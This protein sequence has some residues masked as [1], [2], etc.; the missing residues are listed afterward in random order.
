[1]WLAGSL[2]LMLGLLYL[3]SRAFKAIVRF[4]G[5]VWGLRGEQDLA[6][7]PLALLIFSVLSFLT[8]PAENYMQRVH[9]RASDRYAVEIT[10]DAQAGITA[11]QKLSRLSLSDPNPSPV[12]KFF[13]YS[14][15]TLTERIRDLAEMAKE[16]KKK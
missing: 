7:L 2:V 13:L 6:A 9:E 4:M 12:V 15:P 1:M 10:G 3:L 11:F 8:G 5:G 14:H 16:Q